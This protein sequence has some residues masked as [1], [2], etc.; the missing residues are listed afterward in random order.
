MTRNKQSIGVNFFYIDN[1]RILHTR[2]FL[3]VPPV[4][5]HQC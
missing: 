5:H 4:P 2:I 1:V 3:C